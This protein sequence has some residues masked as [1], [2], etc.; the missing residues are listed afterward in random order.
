MVLCEYWNTI[1]NLMMGNPMTPQNLGLSK[2]AYSVK[3]AMA[4]LSLGRTSI[5]EMMKEG[6][7]KS[8]KCGRR[9]LLLAPDIAIFLS[10]L[11]QEAK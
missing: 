1:T 7:L 5:Y 3:E 4:L 9:T 6:K 10:H 2:A 8:T 11:Q